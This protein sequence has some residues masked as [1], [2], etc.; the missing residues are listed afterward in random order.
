[1]LNEDIR[2]ELEINKIKDGISNYGNKY[3]GHITVWIEIVSH[4]VLEFCLPEEGNV[5]RWTEQRYFNEAG[6]GYWF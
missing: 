3:W 5:E 6:T 1:M 4:S 2:K